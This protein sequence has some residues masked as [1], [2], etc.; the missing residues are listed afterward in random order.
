MVIW[1]N[2]VRIPLW[3]AHSTMDN[4]K[5]PSDGVLNVAIRCTV[6]YCCG[7]FMECDCYV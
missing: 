2:K 1:V 7:E 3:G 6:D 4:Q 5:E